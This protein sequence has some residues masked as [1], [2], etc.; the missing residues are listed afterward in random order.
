MSSGGGGINE[1][2]VTTILANLEPLCNCAT[3]QIF[4]KL[5]LEG[6]EESGGVV[7]MQY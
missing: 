1:L 4:T 3:A 2:P 5:P 7:K 6:G